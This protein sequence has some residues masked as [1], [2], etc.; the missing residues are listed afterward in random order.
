MLCRDKIVAIGLI[1]LAIF[2]VTSVS[3]IADIIVEALKMLEEI[4]EDSEITT[5]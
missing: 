4:K 5:T 3:A 1:V 2:E